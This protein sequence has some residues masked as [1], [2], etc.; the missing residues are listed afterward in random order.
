MHIQDIAI[1][2]FSYLCLS[3][4]IPWYSTNRYCF[5]TIDVL[6]LFSLTFISPFPYFFPL[7]FSS[8]PL[9]HSNKSLLF[10]HLQLGG[11]WVLWQSL[12]VP[13]LYPYS[14]FFLFPISFHVLSPSLLLFIFRNFRSE[15]SFQQKLFYRSYWNLVYCF[16]WN[17]FSWSQKILRFL[18]HLSLWS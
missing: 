8:L 14:D 3:T 10:L 1:P 12:S 13:A 9:F 6:I 4:I 5:S 15:L 16:Y 7:Y 18:F 2:M 11:L 17:N